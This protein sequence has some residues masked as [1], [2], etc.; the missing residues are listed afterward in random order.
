MKP[1]GISFIELH[2]EKI[3]LAV[4]ALAA[5]GVV[6]LQF[7]G[8]GNTVS[9]GSGGDYRLDQAYEQVAQTAESKLGQLESNT[10][11]PRTPEADSAYADRFIGALEERSIA[12]A[13]APLSRPYPSIGPGGPPPGEELLIAAVEPPA[14]PAP[15]TGVF[16]GTIDP[17]TDNREAFDAIYG[18][19][20]WPR[21]V[22]AITVETQIDALGLRQLLEED[23]DGTGPLEP[24][25]VG[26]WRNRHLVATLHFERE[27]LLDDGSWGE[28]ALV[29][30]PPGA[31][32][33][34]ELLD[35]AAEEGRVGE[36][37]SMLKSPRGWEVVV[38]A[39][40]PAPAGWW[41]P[42]YQEQLDAGGEAGVIQSALQA[43]V[44]RGADLRGVES[45]PV[46]THDYSVQPG[47]T[48]RYRVRYAIPNPTY[49]F[50]L[51]LAE[52]SKPQAEA[53]FL[54]SAYSGWSD[55]VTAPRES[56][57]F[58]FSA[59][60]GRDNPIAGEASCRLD[61]YGFVDGKW[62]MK[63]E[64]FEP[65][66]AIRVSVTNDSGTARVIDTG[67]RVV[68]VVRASLSEPGARGGR[69]APMQ[70]VA[71]SADEGLSLRE[72]WRDRAS[73]RRR[74]L[75]DE[76]AAP[77]APAPEAARTAPERDSGRE[78]ET[79]RQEDRR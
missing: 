66:E 68:D 7:T 31:M 29:D 53:G 5:L 46:W 33:T 72:V 50:A 10:P 26:F 67:A 18:A 30:A 73:T 17:T 39:T 32:D 20:D 42:S 40:A 51:T 45:D 70:V 77:S 65:G 58:A 34:R 52:E 6:A 36:V 37:L 44:E 55:P 48:Y 54:Y 61:V 21:D 16:L 43:R 28:T 22:R 60:D 75:A 1:K 41:P 71:S 13:S 11:N 24:I 3:F 35:V 64:R 57:W 8:E 15:T 74:E 38:P 47:E 78:R 4:L 25:P 49:G 27:R 14:P 76:I 63:Q 23:P 12:T 59:T 2:C 62:R 56:Y 19:G 79:A 9:V 69:Q